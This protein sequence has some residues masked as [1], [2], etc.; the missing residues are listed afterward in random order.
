MT[1]NYDV[2][3]LPILA[4]GKYKI[5]DIFKVKIIENINTTVNQ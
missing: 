5:G 1:C 4:D 2:L 3:H